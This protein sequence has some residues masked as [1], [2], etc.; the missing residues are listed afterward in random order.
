M[1]TRKRTFT[2]AQLE[3]YTLQLLQERGI[4]LEDI[5]ELVFTLQKDYLPN[6]DMA[7]C[8]E[9]VHSVLEKREVQHAVLTGI[10]LDVM[11]EK[12][13]LFP[14][15]QEIIGSD[16]GLF[17][18]DENLAQAIVNVYGTIGFTNFGYIDKIK[19]GVLKKLNKK[20]EGVCHTFLDDIV[21]AIAAAAS[22]RMAHRWEDEA[23]KK[24]GISATD[25]K[26]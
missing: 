21:G 5:A 10:Q 22:S 4:R 15:L 20:Q 17:G 18:I 3:A 1:T 9:S 13:L 19:P 8:L 12:N 6:L 2:Q 26:Q 24:S 25:A 7:S 23:E 14:P 11:A 16:A